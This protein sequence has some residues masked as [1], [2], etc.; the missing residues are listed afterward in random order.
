MRK[1][2]FAGGSL[3]D[4]NKGCQAL[5]LGGIEF[6]NT[7]QDDEGEYEIIIPTFTRKR[8]PDYSANEEFRH[9]HYVK[10]V[11]YSYSD[12]VIAVWELKFLR[13]KN[14]KNKLA[15]D[16]KDCSLLY[17][18]CGGDSFS[19]IYGIKQF[20]IFVLPTLISYVFSIKHIFAPQTVGPFSSGL[21]KFIAKK[22]L[23]YSNDVYVRDSEFTQT[24]KKWNIPYQRSKDIS[25]YMK[26]EPV[27]NLRIKDGVVGFNISGLAYFNNYSNLE[28]H[29]DSYPF[30]CLKIVQFF[31]NRNIPIYLIPH[32][33]N[34]LHPGKSDDLMAIRHF[35]EMLK[36]KDDI[37]IVENDFNAMQLK[38]IISKSSFFIGTRMHS[39]FASIFSKIPTLGL[40]YSYK[41]KGSFETLGYPDNYIDLNF[42]DSKDIKACI[43]KMEKIFNAEV[44]NI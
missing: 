9:L 31:Q 6:I 42:L 32:T 44:H 8:R 34:T 2:F 16:L 28:G 3:K 24:L 30:L 26:P 13:L 12:I 10:G 33:Y 43:E 23:R 18:V 37:Y 20:L 5:G 22:L 14:P 17:N 41:F 11:G 19:D 25:S 39:C 35:Y 15:V 29:F 21:I 36:I 7:L 27:E 4:S 1:I 40:A 38:Y